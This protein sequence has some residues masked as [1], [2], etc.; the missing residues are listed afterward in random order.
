MT[1][2]F[3]VFSH[4]RRQGV[5]SGEPE[6]WE[7][8][9]LKAAVGGTVPAHLQDAAGRR[10]SITILLFSR[11]L[12]FFFPPNWGQ[13][14]AAAK[15]DGSAGTPPGLHPPVFESHTAAIAAPVCAT[16]SPLTQKFSRVMR[17]APGGSRTAGFKGN[18]EP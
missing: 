15:K 9:L 11:F 13:T 6:L 17:H 8:E 16:L 7:K 1:G 5:S 10:K 3:C 14:R 4:F 12:L 2:E 18:F